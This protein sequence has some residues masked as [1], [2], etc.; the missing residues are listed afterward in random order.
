MGGA[1]AQAQTTSQLPALLLVLEFA[2]GGNGH[3]VVLIRRRGHMLNHP[4]A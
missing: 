3:E 2:V 1:P 4:V